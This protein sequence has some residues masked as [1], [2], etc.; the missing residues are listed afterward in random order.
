MCECHHEF[1]VSFEAF[2]VGV[3]MGRA[4]EQQRME[5]RIPPTFSF[6][7][8]LLLAPIAGCILAVL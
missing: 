4:W 7:L 5:G 8:L 6:W 3:V 2:L 1:M